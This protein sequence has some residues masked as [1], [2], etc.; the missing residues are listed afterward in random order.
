MHS[1]IKNAR[2]YNIT[3]IVNKLIKENDIIVSEKLNVKRMTSNHNLAKSVY[4]ASFNKIC[5]ILGWKAIL[6]GKCYYQVDT[7]YSSS[8]TCSRCGEKT[9]VT[10]NLNI[11]NWECDKCEILHDQDINASTNREK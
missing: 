11:R 6:M 4:D 2:K 7:Y 9:D 5:E 1:K 8:K 10:N 3:R